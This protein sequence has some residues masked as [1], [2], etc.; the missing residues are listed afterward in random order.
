M[1]HLR[2]VRQAMAERV[3]FGAFNSVLLPRKKL[4]FNDFHQEGFLLILVL[5]VENKEEKQVVTKHCTKHWLKGYLDD[6]D[7]K[8]KGGQTQFIA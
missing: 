3:Q 4:E 5:K 1:F 2:D 8:K 6:D 7:R